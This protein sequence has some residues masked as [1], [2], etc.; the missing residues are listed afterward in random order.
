[1]SEWAEVVYKVTDFFAP[2]WERT[3]LWNDPSIGIIWPLKEY[4]QP[5]LSHKDAVGI[6]L[7][8]AELF[9]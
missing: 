8:E 7:R 6:P 2:E 9:D 5:F 4:E 1:M 3:L